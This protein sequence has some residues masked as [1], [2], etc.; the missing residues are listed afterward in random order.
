VDAIAPYLT[1]GAGGN[2]QEL[3]DALQQLIEFGVLQGKRTAGRR[4]GTAGASGAA[5]GRMGG[6]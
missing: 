5:A 3:S 4:A 2:P 6:K 1:A